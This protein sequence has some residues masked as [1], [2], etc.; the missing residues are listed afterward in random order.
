MFAVNHCIILRRI[1]APNGLLA[2]ILLATLLVTRAC[3]AGIDHPRS[4]SSSIIIALAGNEGFQ[5]KLLAVVERIRSM[6]H[7]RTGAYRLIAFDLGLSSADAAALR[8]AVPTLLD[9]LRPF[10]FDNYPPHVAT[11]GCYAW[12]PMLLAELRRD[13]PHQAV[14]W[15]DTAVALAGP[16]PQTV[17]L[18]FFE[19]AVAASKGVGGALSDRTART[20]GELTHPLMVGCDRPC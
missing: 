4:N 6:S 20:L 3:A 7:G 1:M 10:S 17:S 9:E 15:L 13:F 19:R 8:C 11:L 2:G 5:F 16:S 14:V 12:K 18:D